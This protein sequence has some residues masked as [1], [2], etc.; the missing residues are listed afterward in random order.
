MLPIFS[1]GELAVAT[2]LFPHEE[3]YLA[4]DGNGWVAKSN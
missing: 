3:A 2:D 1:F 4:L